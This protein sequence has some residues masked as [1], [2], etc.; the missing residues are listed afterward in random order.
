[1]EFRDEFSLG[2]QTLLGGKG[3]YE[4]GD[5]VGKT[6]Q[7]VSLSNLFENRNYIFSKSPFQL[8]IT[9]KV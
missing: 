7:K 9:F 4:V 6:F 5:F 1:M 3:S 8:V 2:G